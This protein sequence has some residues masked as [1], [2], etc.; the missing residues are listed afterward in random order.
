[1][2]V[3]LWMR[4]GTTHDGNFFLEKMLIGFIKIFVISHIPHYYGLMIS[5]TTHY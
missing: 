5:V 1:M 4:H 3:L 2:D